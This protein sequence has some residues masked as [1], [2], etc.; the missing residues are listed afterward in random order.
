LP[1]QAKPTFTSII[2]DQSGIT[3]TVL[4]VSSLEHA[5]AYYWRVRGIGEG[6]QA[7]P[8]SVAATFATATS[9]IAEAF[10]QQLSIGPNPCHDRL[11]LHLPKGKYVALELHDVLGTVVRSESELRNHATY[12]IDIRDMVAGTYWLVLKGTGGETSVTSI[13]VE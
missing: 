13:I 12:V 10:T 7:G 6:D 11:T 9:G 5:M 3:D 8:W 2:L 4:T 1:V